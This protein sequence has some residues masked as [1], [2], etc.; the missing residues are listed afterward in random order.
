MYADIGSPEISLVVLSPNNP[1]AEKVAAAAGAGTKGSRDDHVH[2]RLTS[3]TRVTLNASGLATVTYTRT[4]DT[5]PAILLTAINPSGRQIFLEVVDDIQT[6]AVYTGCHVKGYR[7]QILPALTGI[8][9]IG[10]LIA[11]LSGFDAFGGSAAGVEI[12]IVAIQP[13]N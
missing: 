1:L 4:F 7:S 11:A 2:P 3:S 6:G 12:S 9:L 13:S 8:L 10:P 5:K